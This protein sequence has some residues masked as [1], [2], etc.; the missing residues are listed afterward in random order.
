MNCEVRVELGATLGQLRYG[1]DGDGALASGKETSFEGFLR[2][3][4]GHKTGVRVIPAFLVTAGN[5]EIMLGLTE[6][7][8][9]GVTTRLHRQRCPLGEPGR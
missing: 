4:F 6:P 2:D 3:L 8:P 7:A 5:D 1:V 9:G